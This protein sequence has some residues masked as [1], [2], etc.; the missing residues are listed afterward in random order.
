MAALPAQAHLFDRRCFRFWANFVGI[1]GPVGLTKGV[2]ASSQGC[3][4]IVIHR[5]ASK[6]LANVTSRCQRVRVPIRAFRIHV[7]QPHLYRSQG[8]FQI[9]ITGITAVRLVA[10]G[11]PFPFRTPV[12][13]FLGLENV[14]T[15]TGKTKGLEAH[16]LKGHVASQD[17]QVGP[18]QLVAILLFDRP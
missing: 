10:G 2:T 9:A 12:N 18:G 6:G 4:F 5:H 13:V 8:V 17:K 15:T 3:C 16:G 7:D 11:Q 14:L 1:T